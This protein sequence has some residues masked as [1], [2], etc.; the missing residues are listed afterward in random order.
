MKSAIE[1]AKVLGYAKTKYGRKRQVP[2]LKS[3]NFN[4]RT[5]GERVAMNMPIQGTAA[6]IMKIAMNTL[7]VKMK[8]LNLKSKL[9]MQ[10]HDE[11]LIEAPDSEVEQVKNL[12]VECMQNAAKLK[13]KLVVEANIGNSWLEAK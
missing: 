12:M 13:I 10:V 11:L 7:Y 4:T 9:I 8:E 1:E 6:D 2:E 5:F 3:A